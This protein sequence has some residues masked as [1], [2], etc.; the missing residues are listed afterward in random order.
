MN[1]F[2]GGRSARGTHL[3]GIVSLAVALLLLLPLTGLAEPNAPPAGTQCACFCAVTNADGS[4]TLDTSIHYMGNYFLDCKRFDN[5]LETCK[6]GTENVLGKT[7]QCTRT[8]N[9]TSTSKPPKQQVP[10]PQTAPF[11]PPATR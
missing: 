4:H 9:P 11:Q 10:R 1:T 7:T 3:V 5:E 8:K 2:I 6:V